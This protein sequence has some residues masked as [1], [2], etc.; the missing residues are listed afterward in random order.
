LSKYNVNRARETAVVKD[1]NVIDLTGL[2]PT[3]YDSKYIILFH[4]T[5]YTGS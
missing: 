5:S 2:R 1:N 4:G 3:M